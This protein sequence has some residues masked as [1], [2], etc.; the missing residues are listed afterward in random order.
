MKLDETLTEELPTN[1]VFKLEFFRRKNARDV[2]N[3]LQH[4]NELRA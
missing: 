3:A 2:V 4:N 1:V